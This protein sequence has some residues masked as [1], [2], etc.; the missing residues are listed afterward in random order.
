[1]TLS[2][3]AI[4]KLKEETKEFRTEASELFRLHCQSGCFTL[5][6]HSLG[7]IDKDLGRRGAL[8]EQHAF[9]YGR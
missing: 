3:V 8:S 7:Q 1:M 6:F 9:T 5:E 4:G 2:S